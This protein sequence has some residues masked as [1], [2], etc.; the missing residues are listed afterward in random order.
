MENLN[1]YAL[2][3]R[4]AIIAAPGEAA[5]GTAEAGAEGAAEQP[6]FDDA[7]GFGDF[8]GGGWRAAGAG[9]WQQQQWQQRSSSRARSSMHTVRAGGQAASLTGAPLR[10]VFLS[11]RRL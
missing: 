10:P 4:N 9:A 7:D 2:R 5:A 1:R 8:G 11:G 3:P 6:A